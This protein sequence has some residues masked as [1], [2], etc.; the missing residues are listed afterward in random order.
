MKFFLD[1]SISVAIWIVQSSNQVLKLLYSGTSKNKR[2]RQEQTIRGSNY[3]CL[4]VCFAFMVTKI[5][6]W[7]KSLKLSLKSAVLQH[8]FWLCQNFSC[9]MK[10]IKKKKLGI[11]QHYKCN[12]ISVPQILAWKNDSLYL[13]FLGDLF[14]IKVLLHW[15]LILYLFCEWTENSVFRV[16]SLEALNAYTS[17]LKWQNVI[18]AM[19]LTVIPTKWQYFS[20]CRR[21]N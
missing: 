16:T 18:R 1:E 13:T 9:C 3:F 7:G 4:F 11:L 6:S 8:V 17:T 19:S 2:R 5:S 20:L 15:L 10:Q 12:C 21:Q 14:Y